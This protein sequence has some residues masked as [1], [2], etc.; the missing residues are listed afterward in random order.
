VGRGARGS[1]TENL[2]TPNAQ[3][4]LSGKLPYSETRRAT[5]TMQALAMPMS[6]PLNRRV[7]SGYVL[8][9]VGLAYNRP[10]AATV[11]S[12]LLLPPP[13]PLVLRGRTKASMNKSSVV[14]RIPI[15]CVDQR[16]CQ[17]RCR[18]CIVSPNQALQFD[19][20]AQQPALQNYRGRSLSPSLC[21]CMCLASPH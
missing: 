9:Y 2:G 11:S 18:R 3:R 14:A 20:V 13:P 21:R 10:H 4:V 12:I 6:P 8:S 15:S 7:V 17:R 19:R 5:S 16:W 1:P